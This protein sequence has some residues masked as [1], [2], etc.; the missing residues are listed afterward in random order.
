MSD[1]AYTIGSDIL[2]AS[3]SSIV[4]F[5][6][7]EV[8]VIMPGGTTILPMAPYSTV[9]GD[10][11][12]VY[13]VVVTGGI[14][15]GGNGF[16]L[17]VEDNRPGQP[18][19]TFRFSFAYTSPTRVDVYLANGT[20]FSYEAPGSVT[21]G[22]GPATKGPLAN[23]MVMN[24][25]MRPT[26]RRRSNVLGA[27]PAAGGMG[28]A[29]GVV[30]YEMIIKQVGAGAS[31]ISAAAGGAKSE[32]RDIATDI[33]H[34]LNFITA[35]IETDGDIEKAKKLYGFSP[36]DAPPAEVAPVQ[37]AI[38]QER[39]AATVPGKTQ[40][41]LAIAKRNLAAY[42]AH[43][44]A[45]PIVDPRF[46]DIIANPEY[47]AVLRIGSDKTD[48][49][50]DL[51]QVVV[52]GGK[53]FAGNGY[54]P[55]EGFGQHFSFGYDTPARVDFTTKS[56]LS[57]SLMDVS[58]IIFGGGQ[59]T[60][61]VAGL[62]EEM[63]ADKILG[64]LIGAA[65]GVTVSAPTGR[66][67]T[68]E[69]QAA[70]LQDEAAANAA[71]YAQAVAEL[72]A[73]LARQAAED[74][75]AQQAQIAPVMAAHV[76]KCPKCGFALHIQGAVIGELVAKQPAAVKQFAAE[77]PNCGV[78]LKLSVSAS[79][80]APLPP[81]PGPKAPPKPTRFAKML[82]PKLR[83]N[84]IKG[85][86]G[87]GGDVTQEDVD[88]I[89]GEV[90]GMTGT[91][92]ISTVEEPEEVS[93]N[94][95]IYGSDVLIGA[96]KY[97]SKTRAM[98]GKV[99]P[100]RAGFV[101]SKSP[102][103]RNVL[104][105]R[106][107]A[108]RPGA[109]QTTASNAKTVGL[110]VMKQGQDLKDALNKKGVFALAPVLRKKTNV[111][112]A[113]LTRRGG[114][115]RLMKR[116]TLSQMKAV[117]QRA[118]SDGAK[119]VQK[120][121]TFENKVA[122]A[123]AKRAAGMKRMA[124]GGKNVSAPTGVRDPNYVPS[125]TLP[126]A[127]VPPPTVSGLDLLGYVDAVIGAPWPGYLD[128]AA[129][130]CDP[131]PKWDADWGQGPGGWMRECQGTG[132]PSDI[133]PAGSTPPAGTPPGVPWTPRALP[134]Q[135]TK[136]DVAP[137][138][139]VDYEPAPAS[140]EHLGDM[141]IEYHKVPK[142]GVPWDASGSIP[143]QALGSYAYFTGHAPQATAGSG[144]GFVWNGSGWSFSAST[145]GKEDRYGGTT[146]ELNDRS[147]KAN[148]GPLI[149]SPKPEKQFFNRLHYSDGTRES[150]QPA[151]NL[152]GELEGVKYEPCFFW[153][154]DQAPPNKVAPL[155]NARLE[156]AT[157][158]WNTIVLNAQK[159]AEIE[160]VKDQLAKDTKRDLDKSNVIR[161]AA[162]ADR[163]RKEVEES[164][165][166]INLSTTEQES[167]LSQ[168]DVDRE[169]AALETENA[170]NQL[171]IDQERGFMQQQQQMMDYYAQNPQMAYGGGYGGEGYGGEYERD[172]NDL[173]SDPNDPGNVDW[174]DGQ[175]GSYE[176][177]GWGGADRG[178]GGPTSLELMQ[179]ADENDS[180]ADAES[181]DEGSY[182][183]A[184]YDE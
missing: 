176:E 97:E 158:K 164:E 72:E 107:T 89:Y 173:N 127:N 174:G 56:G 16:Q 80:V 14:A 134:P 52:A 136:D 141:A 182:D 103:G 9:L 169:R 159:E 88:R 157:I 115:R 133:P 47:V 110:R 51:S 57:A 181:F 108:T 3:A 42:E 58:K 19:H 123:N 101:L 43:R 119:L 131:D 31:G 22:A 71:A 180:G 33:F 61:R 117:A 143:Y 44:R 91:T 183:E 50:G 128:E 100:Q 6:P 23:T 13:K 98:A 94:D 36:K 25:A 122:M 59:T 145:G 96:A 138:P 32:K 30:P 8:A 26:L 109:F 93:E 86:E 129:T 2:G 156:E 130:Q 11:K 125:N 55:G 83:K 85:D 74:A 178:D 39:K 70:R 102:A 172:P 75:Q 4:V 170:A 18:T 21:F 40:M 48:L 139:F 160:A 45:N 150:P 151:N 34:P 17:G 73:Q 147:L 68:A 177:E 152:L 104:S 65:R 76:T 165:H 63:S 153:F 149:G 154:F 60:T 126:R 121:T 67:E 99:I 46:G 64:E 105:L 7:F 84:V 111:V 15:R 66:R 77:C 179:Q 41:K 12:S 118:I 114:G 29:G 116:F 144:G 78:A 87:D 35:A 53:H 27:M 10:P 168:I 62:E 113:T 1:L 24:R 82:N 175:G 135:P 37:A 161:D 28:G 92:E 120:A 106:I 95:Y 38:V 163:I 124:D 142:G 69:E 112:G 166:R 132:L 5:N 162:D 155:L 140:D 137:K 79:N 90:L 167:A 54:Q 146:A 81:M 184:A 171:A 20:K 49:L 148:Y